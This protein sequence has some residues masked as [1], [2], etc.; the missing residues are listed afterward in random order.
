MISLH[1]TNWIGTVAKVDANSDGKGVLEIEIAKNIVVKTWNNELSDIGS[2][3]LIEPGTSLFNTASMFKEGQPIKF[4]GT[5]FRGNSGDCVDE[6]SLT[7]SGKLRD[8]E[9]VFRF[10][11]VAAS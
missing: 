8:P 1:V 5:F 4:S 2:R 11:G 3:T 7:L 10:S 9:F 6:S